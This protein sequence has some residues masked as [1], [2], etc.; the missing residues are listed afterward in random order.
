MYY[1]HVLRKLITKLMEFCEAENNVLKDL[2]PTQ[3]RVLIC[4][5][6]KIS[7]KMSPKEKNPHKKI[8]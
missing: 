8:P 1:I 5:L 4:V 6:G 2:H 3:I 7:T